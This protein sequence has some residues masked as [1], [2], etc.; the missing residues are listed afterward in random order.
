V[1]PGYDQAA[2]RLHAVDDWLGATERV[3]LAGLD[4]RRGD[5]LRTLKNGCASFGAFAAISG[6]SQK[7]LSSLAT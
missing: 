6:D 4:V 3:P 5:G 2:G 1:C 7:S